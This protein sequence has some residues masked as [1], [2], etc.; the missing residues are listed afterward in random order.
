M[1]AR[2]NIKMATMYSTIVRNSTGACI[3]LNLRFGRLSLW[4]C[5][6]GILLTAWPFI[7]RDSVAQQV[8]VFLFAGIMLYFIG[9]ILSIIAI[10]KKEA[11]KSKFFGV[12]FILLIA[13]LSIFSLL[14]LSLGIGGK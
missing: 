6:A 5:T 2:Y 7:V 10:V 14:L 9:V 13:V 3:R 8:A 1:N 11:G 12:F 4:F